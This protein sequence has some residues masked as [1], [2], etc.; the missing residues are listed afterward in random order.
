MKRWN[1]IVELPAQQDIAECRLWIAE[2]D[3]ESAD[4]WFYEIYDTI[5]SLEIFPDRCPLAPESI[6]LNC[7]IREIFHGRRQYKYRILFTLA[8]NDVHVLHVRHGA[9]LALGEAA[10]EEGI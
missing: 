6:F 4:C 1:V 8:E 2:R 7:D 5:G 9:R 10:P 3:V